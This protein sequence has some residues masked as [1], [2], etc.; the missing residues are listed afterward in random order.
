MRYVNEKGCFDLNACMLCNCVVA[1]AGRGGSENRGC[2]LFHPAQQQCAAAGES[3]LPNKHNIENPTPL[4]LEN[5][6]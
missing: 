4:K 1:S 2:L 6:M 5:L 3:G